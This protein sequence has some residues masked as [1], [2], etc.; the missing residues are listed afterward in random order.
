MNALT[1]AYPQNRSL[2][3]LKPLIYSMNI[4]SKKYLNKVC[5]YGVLIFCPLLLSTRTY[6]QETNKSNFSLEIKVNPITASHIGPLKDLIGGASHT[7]KNYFGLTVKGSYSMS[8]RWSLATGIGYSTQKIITVL[9]YD[10][11]PGN[12][13]TIKDQLQVWEIPLEVNYSISKYFFTYAGPLLHFQQKEVYALDKQAGIGVQIGIGA[14]IPLNS[15]FTIFA[16]P[17]Y[18][19]Y[20]LIPFISKRHDD[21]MQL[22]GVSFGL[23]YALN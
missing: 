6:T 23:K 10:G 9:P 4:K 12:E 13:R 18:K 7:G 8:E 17:S 22:F 3:L 15:K 16:S 20:S 2:Y 21:K 1:V 5:Y 14:Q 19:M 11:K